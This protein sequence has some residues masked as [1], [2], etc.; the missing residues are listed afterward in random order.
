MPPPV[1][2]TLFSFSMLFPSVQLEQVWYL[3]GYFLLWNGATLAMGSPFI[4][5]VTDT[6]KAFRG[7]PGQALAVRG[8]IKSGLAA[9]RLPDG[10]GGGG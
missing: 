7:L 9:A 2:G 6:P 1:P 8:A 4:L 10:T 5:E 3:P